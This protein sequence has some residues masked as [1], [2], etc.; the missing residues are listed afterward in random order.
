MATEAA[1]Q[2]SSRHRSGELGTRSYSD[3][4][5]LCRRR[6]KRKRSG[7]TEWG[8]G[9]SDGGLTIPVTGGAPRRSGRRNRCRARACA[10][11]SSAA[12]ASA[13]P[14]W[15]PFLAPSWLGSLATG[16]GISVF[17]FDVSFVTLQ[18]N[19]RPFFR[20]AATGDLGKKKSIDFLFRK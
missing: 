8:G 12:Q 10:E 17:C 5:V 7:R 3:G 2:S 4:V 6:S 19:Q 15:A 20:C 16:I 1:E 14:A 11:A 13:P 18:R 9:E